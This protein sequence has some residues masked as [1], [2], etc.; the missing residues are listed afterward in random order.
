MVDIKKFKEEGNI[1][2]IK[3]QRGGLG[4]MKDR[5]F[6]MSIQDVKKNLAA[7]GINCRMN[8]SNEYNE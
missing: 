6:R 5:I 3:Q 1:E 7:S 4:F 2:F 8:G